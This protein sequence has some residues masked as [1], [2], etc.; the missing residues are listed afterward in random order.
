MANNYSARLLNIAL[1]IVKKLK[2]KFFPPIQE[3]FAEKKIITGFNSLIKIFDEYKVKYKTVEIEENNFLNVNPPFICYLKNRNKEFFFVLVT[4]VTVGQVEYM[5]KN[6][7]IN[8]VSKKDFFA[9]IMPFC[10][11]LQN[12]G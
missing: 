11:Q 7:K 10:I 12:S 2:F 4:F 9:D 5:D 3:T 8:K 1:S 6:K